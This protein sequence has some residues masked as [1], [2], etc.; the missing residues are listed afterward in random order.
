MRIKFI[1]LVI[2]QVLLLAGMIAYREHWVA[3]GERILLRTA[4]VD[5]TDIFRGDYVSLDYEISTLDLDDLGVKEHFNLNE[6]IYV[7][8]EKRD[9]GTFA[10]SSVSKTVPSA[11]PFIQG[12]TL[13]E[14][15]SS[16][17][18]V[19]VREN[20]GDIRTF[21][22]RWFSGTNKG[23]LVT[24]C[25]DE[26]N[27]VRNY[28][29]ID[30]KY[31]QKCSSG[32][33]VSGVVEDIKETKFRQ[34]RVKYGIESYFVEEGAGRAI[35]TARNARKVTVEVSLRK[36]GKGIITALFLDGVEVAR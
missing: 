15:T 29:K 9:D 14:T 30:Q 20:S 12:R 10:A 2:L 28:F 32:N 27:N 11:K 13:T 16:R 5:P 35:E 25:I 7:L 31:N 24:F 1:M 8:L 26:S 6:K 3:S 18:E 21:G 22:P 23:D 33:S 17:W 4:P 19:T 34:L 36:D